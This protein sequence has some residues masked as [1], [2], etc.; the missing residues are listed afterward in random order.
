[1]TM[2]RA[3]IF[4]KR[5]FKI[6]GYLWRKLYDGLPSKLAIFGATIEKVVNEIWPAVKKVL[7]EL[8]IS[9][10]KILVNTDNGKVTNGTYSATG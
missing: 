7:S 6:S 4:W 9:L 2:S 10:N 8:D 3:T 1:M 5:L